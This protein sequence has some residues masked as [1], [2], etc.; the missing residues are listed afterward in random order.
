MDVLSIQA[1]QKDKK[2]LA[3]LRSSGI[4]A[5]CFLPLNGAYV[6][7]DLASFS[8]Q[9]YLKSYWKLNKRK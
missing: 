9:Y 2:Q 4:I 7:V 5:S 6:A 8:M 3:V 1:I